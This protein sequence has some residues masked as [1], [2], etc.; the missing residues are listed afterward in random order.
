MEK[1]EE[2]KSILVGKL[3]YTKASWY[4][5]EHCE[6]EEKDDVG[7]A[8]RG[9]NIVKNIIQEVCNCQS[10]HSA[11]NIKAFVF[12]QRDEMLSRCFK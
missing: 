6:Y 9:M 11:D 10:M 5:K 8:E 3:V 7:G 1:K 2:G 12:L 4:R